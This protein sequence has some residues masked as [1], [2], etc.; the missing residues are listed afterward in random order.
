MDERRRPD[1][2][3]RVTRKE[4][5]ARMAYVEDALARLMPLRELYPLFRSEFGASQRTAERYVR[6]V[7]E[8]WNSES[9]LSREQKRAEIERA[10]DLAFRV[11]LARKDSRA[12]T[13]ALELKAK[14]HGLLAERHE[15]SGPNGKPIETSTVARVV[16]LPP[17]ESDDNGSPVA[18][19][20]GP[21]NEVPREPC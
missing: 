7:H 4:V 18:P 19:E 3:R 15:H 1:G 20:P 2:N 13:S 16:M 5:D 6:R 8:R 21:T 12:A 10:A 17:I 11:A 14:L 9:T